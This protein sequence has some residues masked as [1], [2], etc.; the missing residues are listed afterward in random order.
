MTNAQ[1]AREWSLKKL[2]D[3]KAVEKHFVA[4]STNA[5]AV[6]KFGI[7]TANM[8]GFW[9]W[10][11]GVTPWTRPSACRPCWPLA[12]DFQ[13]MLAGFHAIDK[14]FRT[15]PFAT[16]LPSDGLLTVCTTGLFGAA[17][18]AVLPYDHT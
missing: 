2:K 11:G 3:E 15:T 18:V 5:K 9:D 16:N 14:H 12:R 17:T 4:V 7:D 10:V 1:T 13:E 8:F 6:S